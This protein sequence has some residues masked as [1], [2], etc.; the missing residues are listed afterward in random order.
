[1]T[2]MVTNV[3]LLGDYNYHADAEANVYS[4]TFFS[5]ERFGLKNPVDMET[6]IKGNIFNLVITREIEFLPMVITTDTTVTSDYVAVVFGIRAPK[7]LSENKSAKSGRWKLLNLD[8]F[9]A[10]LS[11]GYSLSSKI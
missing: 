8:A 1:M 9:K 2:K 10:D 3:S 11:V 6:H 7:P 5:L 4:K